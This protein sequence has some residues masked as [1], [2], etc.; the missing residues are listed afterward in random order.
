MGGS[1]AP[2]RATLAVSE[3]RGGRSGAGV[4]NYQRRADLSRRRNPTQESDDQFMP[5]PRAVVFDMDGLMFNTE[6]VYYQ[7]GCEVLR[8]RGHEFTKE[9]SDAMMGRP[10]Q[11]SFELMIQWHSLDDTWRQLSVESEGVF[12]ELLDGYLA[13]MPGLLE[14]LDYLEQAGIPK[15]I[16]TSSS[17]NVL[18][19]VLSRMEMEPR[20]QFTL[21]AEDIVEGKPAPEIYLKAAARFQLRPAEMLVLEDSSTGCRAAAAAGAFAV[22]VPGEHSRGQDFSVASLVIDSLADPRLYAVL[23]ADGGE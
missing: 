15:A 5:P 19:A 6:D 23:R 9:L 20:F 2:A 16:C 18:S 21:T 22:A 7:V 17:R 11:P 10:P 14:L 1:I 4:L 3:A 8:R 12:V 13:P